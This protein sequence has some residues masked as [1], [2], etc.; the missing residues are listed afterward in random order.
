MKKRRQVTVRIDEAVHR[1]LAEYVQQA[2]DNLSMADI[3][4]AGLAHILNRLENR[5]LERH[6][7]RYI[8]E[9]SREV[10][11]TVDGITADEFPLVLRHIERARPGARMELTI[12]RN[13]D[14]TLRV[15]V[16]DVGGL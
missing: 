3:C 14:D 7:E 5:P 2:R 9:Q 1:R 10:P 15:D 16:H 8:D 6:L 13:D 12:V 11:F 4:R